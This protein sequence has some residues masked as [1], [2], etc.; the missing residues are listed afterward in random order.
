MRI[1]KLRICIVDDEKAYFT[2][3][4]LRL[5][6][7]A[8]LSNIER[9]F[10]IDQELLGNLLKC[11]PDII[12][13]DIKGVTIPDVAKDGFHVAKILYEQTNAFVVITS[14]HKFHL[15]EYHRSYDYVMQERLLTAIDFIDE[16]WKIVEDYLTRKTKFFRKLV[17]KIGY[18][19]AKKSMTQNAF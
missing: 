16:L 7:N 11:P 14:A 1:G 15:H 18:K 4:M 10:K 3:Q 17:F 5:A 13:L 8:G 12:I 9:H 2:P 19:I 6:A